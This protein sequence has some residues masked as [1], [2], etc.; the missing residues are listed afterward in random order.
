M[1]RP[2]APAPAFGFL[3]LVWPG[4]PALTSDSSGDAL[5]LVREVFPSDDERRAAVLAALRER[6]KTDVGP[7]LD[8]PKMIAALDAAYLNEDDLVFGDVINGDVRAYAGNGRAFSGVDDQTDHVTSGGE[9]W[10]VTEDALIG[11]G[12]QRLPRLAGHIA[13]WF[14]WQS[15]KPGV[16]LLGE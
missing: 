16:A 9:T 10:T 4:V 6:G 12:G 2:I 7:A 1:G 8:H 15:F 11:P 14:A 13:Y 5:H 3:L